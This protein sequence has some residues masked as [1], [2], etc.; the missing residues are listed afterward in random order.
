M[1][2]AVDFIIDGLGAEGLQFQAWPNDWARQGG[3]DYN[4]ALNAIAYGVRKFHRYSSNIYSPISQALKSF[5]RL[6]DSRSPKLSI[7]WD[8]T[9]ERLKRAYNSLLW[10]EAA[11]LYRDNRTTSLHPQDGN[12]LAVYFNLTT[13]PE[14]QKRVSKGLTR[15]WNDIGPVT[16]ELPDTISPFVSSWEVR[17]LPVTIHPQLIR[18]SGGGTFHR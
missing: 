8:H 6:A 11:G 2:R 17:T 18:F 7:S 10:N 13:S 9:A 3:G 1:T 12:A 15:N 16:P 14:Q 5:S 4:S